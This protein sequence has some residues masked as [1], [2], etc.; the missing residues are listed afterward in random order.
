MELAANGAPVDCTVS[1]TAIQAITFEPVTAATFDFRP[2]Q[3]LLLP[4]NMNHAVL[5]A[6]FQQP[7]VNVTIT[8]DN[9]LAVIL[10]D[11]LHYSVST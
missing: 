7:L 8:Q 11:N 9:S 3:G 2:P 6:R 1:V 4:V 5:P 10:M